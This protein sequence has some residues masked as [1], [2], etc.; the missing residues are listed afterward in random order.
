VL[1]AFTTATQFCRVALNG[2]DKSEQRTV[3]Q[4]WAVLEQHF[5]EYESY[6]HEKDDRNRR[7]EGLA[8][9]VQNTQAQLENIK[10]LMTLM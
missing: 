3:E 6:L 8:S 1:Q 2:V 5:R 4:A 7:R 9:L 10:G